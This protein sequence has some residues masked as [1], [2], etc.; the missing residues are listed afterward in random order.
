M[1]PFVTVPSVLVRAG[2]AAD[3][4]ALGARRQVRPRARARRPP[5]VGLRRSALGSTEDIAL[6]SIDQSKVH[7]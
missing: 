7:S 2:A 5:R 1:A 6:I 4:A 3:V